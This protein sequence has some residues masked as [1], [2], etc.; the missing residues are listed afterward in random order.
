MAGELIEFDPGKS[1]GEPKKGSS[2]S[3]MLVDDQPVFREVARALLE[4]DGDFDVVAEASDGIDAV[5]M[6]DSV[7]PD[8]VIMDIQMAAMSGIEATRKILAEHPGATVVL[9]SMTAESEYLRLVREIG[10]LAFIAKRN[11]NAPSLRSVLDRGPSNEPLA[12]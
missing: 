2:V 3:I 9:T 4:R 8:V 5:S 12:A 7:H 10:A 1:Y 6:V 11:L